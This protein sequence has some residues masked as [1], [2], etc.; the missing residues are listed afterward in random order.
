MKAMSGVAVVLTLTLAN[1][2]SAGEVQIKQAKEH[3]DFLVDGE[4]VGRYL[5]SA[6]R[7][8][9]IFWPLKAPGGAILTR[10]WPMEKAAEG[11]SVDHPHQ[12][13]AWFC[14]GDV[15]PEGITVTAKI[16]KIK[17]VDFWSV[18]PGHGKIICTKVETPN[19]NKSAGHLTTQNE[20]RTSD[21]IKIMDETRK[22][23]L[24]DFDKA[25]LLVFD[26]DLLASVVP[27]VFGD[28]KEGSMG[29]RVNDVIRE[30]NG[31]GQ[32]ANAEGKKG[33]KE[34]WGQHS[35]WCDYSGTV[36]GQKVGIAVLCDPKNAE[37][38]AYHVRDYGLMA[39]NPFGR[40][41][42]AFPAVK[43]KKD[44]VRLEKGQHLRLRYG[45]LL[46]TGDASS[47][48]VQSCF[49]RFVALRSAE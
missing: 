35:V 43:G 33:S 20:W 14:H 45:I 9:P 13:S 49:D 21:D 46:H 39:A 37:P 23:H 28:T 19:T 4:L 47:G 16:P 18:A 5:I 27:I 29:V 30:K 40:A 6:E 24:Y 34:C 1:L 25:R 2:M 36:D 22:L 15:I 38:S 10:A 7:P 31:N 17:G 32:I 42:A 48:Q 8:K 12:Q 41:E 44:L 26:I 3:V 11:G